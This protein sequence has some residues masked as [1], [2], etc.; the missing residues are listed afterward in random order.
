MVFMSDLYGVI[1][2]RVRERPSLDVWERC[3]N[4]LPRSLLNS[5][6][7]LT[8]KIPG[9]KEC[10]HTRSAKYSPTTSK[11]LNN[12]PLYFNFGLQLPFHSC[13]G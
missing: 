13:M 3:P 12:R 11:C 8:Q 6:S 5:K 2:L 1:S 10:Y 4:F 7:T 9:H